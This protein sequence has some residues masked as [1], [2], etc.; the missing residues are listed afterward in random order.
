LNFA[1]REY[2]KGKY[3]DA[4]SFCFQITKSQFRRDEFIILTEW[5]DERKNSGKT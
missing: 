4:A 2:A 5:K 3:I 1:L